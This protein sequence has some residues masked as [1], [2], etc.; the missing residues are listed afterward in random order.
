M[1]AALCAELDSAGTV[2]RGENRHQHR[3]D[4]CKGAVTQKCADKGG[5]RR[6]RGGSWKERQG[7]MERGEKM[8]WFGQQPVCC[9]CCCFGSEML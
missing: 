3:R 7:G 1:A 8:K 9:L 2:E 4:K 6:K 5:Y